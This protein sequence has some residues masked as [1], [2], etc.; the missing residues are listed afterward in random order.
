M[1][2]PI[3]NTTGS[4]TGGATQASSPTSGGT[5]AA[6]QNMFLQLLVAQLKNQD[7]TEPMNSSTFVTQLAQM[8]QLEQSTTT[9]QDVTAMHSD[10]DKI[11]A[12]LSGSTSQS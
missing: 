3:A 6:T 11:V 7:P 1:I 5:V 12:D 4:S 2:A 9:G 8:Q 10:L